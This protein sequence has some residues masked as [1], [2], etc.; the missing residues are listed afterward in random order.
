MSILFFYYFNLFSTFF[1]SE[2][3]TI[4]AS[5]RQNSRFKQPKQPLQADK[6]EGPVTSVT[7][8]TT[9]PHT[10]QGGNPSNIRKPAASQA[11]RQPI[12]PTGKQVKTAPRRSTPKENA[13]RF[14]LKISGHHDMLYLFTEKH[15]KES[16]APTNPHRNCQATPRR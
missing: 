12:K 11:Y 3:N 4:A 8:P 5:N 2:I 14:R 13:P 1:K 6:K 16:H 15:S 7:F 9:E 10:Q